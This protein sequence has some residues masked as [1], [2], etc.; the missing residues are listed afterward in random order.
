MTPGELLSVYMHDRRPGW[1]T[2][3]DMKRWVD[4]SY[5]HGWD[6]AELRLADPRRGKE[7]TVPRLVTWVVL[8]P[9]L[10]HGQQLRVRVD[11]DTGEIFAP[12]DYPLE[13]DER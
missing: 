6:I 8:R 12:W 13:A 2:W 3:G 4:D 10:A 9:D 1:P 11:L 7:R 5:R